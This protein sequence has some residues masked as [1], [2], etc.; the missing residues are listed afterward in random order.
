MKKKSETTL[1]STAEYRRFIEELKSRILSAQISAAR[2]INHELIRLYWDIGRG[3][4]EKQK[5]LGWGESVVEMIAADLQ[6]AFP[7]MSG[8]SPRNVWDMRRLYEAY[9]A[10]EFLAAAMAMTGQGGAGSILRQPVAE[11][12]REDET[13]QFLQQLV[14]EVPWG[15][16]LLILNKLTDPAARLWYLSGPF[17]K[18]DDVFLQIS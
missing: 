10:P 6:R 4:V 18:Y 8:F 13:G 12:K 7:S 5:T 16:N 14:S 2:R 11:F 15:Q 1:L 9:S 3:I 17:H